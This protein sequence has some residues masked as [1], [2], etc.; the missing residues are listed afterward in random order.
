MIERAG[1]QEG[2]QHHNTP[3]PITTTLQA[4]ND[5]TMAVWQPYI[6]FFVQWGGMETIFIYIYICQW[7][8]QGFSFQ[9]QYIG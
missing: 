1:E 7:T 9:M 3:H 6:F 4:P 2:I 8:Q 5:V